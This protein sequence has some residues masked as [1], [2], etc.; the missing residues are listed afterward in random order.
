MS[1]PR[2]TFALEKTDDAPGELR[3]YLNPEGR[4]LLVKELAHRSEESDH[5]HLQDEDWA[6]E[7][8][9]QTRAYVPDRES[10]VDAVKIMLRPDEW[11]REY[12]SHVLESEVE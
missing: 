3:I 9:L 10:I 12:F 4:N 2:I 8:P 6:I 7:V 1:K 11:D 5:F